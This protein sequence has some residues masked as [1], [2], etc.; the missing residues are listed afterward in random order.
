M[1]RREAS[2]SAEALE[3]KKFT[4]RKEFGSR[5][6]TG[7][8]HYRNKP[9]RWAKDCYKRKRKEGNSEVKTKTHTGSALIQEV[10]SS[11]VRKKRLVLS[12]EELDDKVTIKLGNVHKR[13]TAKHLSE[14]LYVQ[15][16]EYNQFSVSATSD[17][18]YEVMVNDQKCLVKRKGVIEAVGERK[19][20]SFVIEVEVIK[21]LNY[22]QEEENALL[23]KTKIGSIQNWHEKLAHQH[24][25]R[26]F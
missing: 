19:G 3:A 10:I 16:L 11:H 4:K 5:K 24:T 1:K 23:R 12:L 7:N 21:P 14:V 17:K 20:G 25:S 18:G 8:R 26:K 15:G 13:W 9:A 6:E 22:D 2:D